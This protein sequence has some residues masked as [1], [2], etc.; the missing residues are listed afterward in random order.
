M[1]FKKS[2]CID[3]SKLERESRTLFYIGY[4]I[5]IMF[6]ASLSL[7][8]SLRPDSFPLAAGTELPESRK[9][10]P[11]DFIYIR[12]Q[13][14]SPSPPVI[15]P[16]KTEPP[17][18]V[19]E[20]IEETIPEEETPSILRQP[21]PPAKFPNLTGLKNMPSGAKE[22]LRHEISQPDT[23]RMPESWKISSKPKPDPTVTIPVETVKDTR[24]E[25]RTDIFG[26][27]LD[28][29]PS[30]PIH[31]TR[32]APNFLK[33]KF[34]DIMKKRRIKKMAAGHFTAISEK[35]VRLM[36]LAWRDGLLDTRTLSK[37]DR[38]FIA[39]GQKPDGK[40]ILNDDYLLKMEKRGLVSSLIFDGILV[41]RANFL[42]EAILETLFYERL[43]TADTNKI[44]ALDT[45]I[46]LLQAHPDSA[47]KE[48]TIPAYN[49]YFRKMFF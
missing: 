43:H 34:R 30:I 31:L 28:G 35:D 6:T 7:F 21:E 42:R 32:N 13:T 37:S 16:R 15:E 18:V 38:E 41:F 39:A 23:V 27:H 17:A 8:I 40:I 22:M 19:R 9:H 26:I 25:F 4:V 12:P 44:A 11:V 47:K 36:I 1:L 46:G 49:S 3:I 2:H 33:W 10:I 24:R 45:F 5:G 29:I 20:T 14:E 48:I